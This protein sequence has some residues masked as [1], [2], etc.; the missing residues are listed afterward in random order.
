MY[1]RKREKVLRDNNKYDSF[2][3]LSMHNSTYLPSKHNINFH[4]IYIL[5]IVIVLND[6]VNHT[7]IHSAVDM[8]YCTVCTVKT[9]IM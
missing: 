7:K 9:Y 8:Y 1:F 5:I 3:C 6:A 2:S 4:N